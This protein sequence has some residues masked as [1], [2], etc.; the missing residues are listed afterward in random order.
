MDNNILTLESEPIALLMQTIRK[1]MK[2]A[3]RMLDGY[4]P[5]FQGD[6]YL[7]DRE[8]SEKLHVSRR[9]LQEY[10]NNGIL[11]YILFGGK[12]LYRERDIQNLLD[13]NYREAY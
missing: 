7:T 3:D 6:R 5:P 12:V 13:K 11:P 10:R 4:T 8:I 9:T 1:S 2:T